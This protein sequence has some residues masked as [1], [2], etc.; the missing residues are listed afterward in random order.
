MQQSLFD[1]LKQKKEIT[2]QKS[3]QIR[4]PSK[5][6]LNDKILKSCKKMLPLY[7]SAI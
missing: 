1:L 7:E 6:K 3:K 2:I 4:K 5:S